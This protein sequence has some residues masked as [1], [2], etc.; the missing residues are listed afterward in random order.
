MTDIQAALGVSQFGGIDENIRQRNETAK[1]YDEA[2]AGIDG[3]IIPPNVG[4]DILRDR[5][6]RDV[7][8]R[9][10]YTLRLSDA[11]R[12]RALYDHLHEAGVLAQVHYIPLHIMPYYRKR[13]GYGPGDYPRAEAYYASEIS[14]PLYHEMDLETREYVID[15]VTGFFAGRSG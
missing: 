15:A 14:L 4:Y 2:F 7:H 5:A 9:H 6:A 1:R 10:L 8:S 3:V 12:R 13:F 11:G